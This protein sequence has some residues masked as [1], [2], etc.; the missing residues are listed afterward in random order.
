MVRRPHGLDRFVVPRTVI[1][2]LVGTE[3]LVTFHNRGALLVDT[4]LDRP[5]PDR[6]QEIH[7]V[8]RIAKL[9]DLV[10]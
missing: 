2:V 9:K 6:P 7:L 5:H 1:E 4:G 3:V 10:C 8:V